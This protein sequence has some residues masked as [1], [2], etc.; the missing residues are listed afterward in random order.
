MPKKLS[1]RIKS[2][3][4]IKHE[5]NKRNGEKLNLQELET[6]ISCGRVVF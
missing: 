4:E 3:A 2:S 5:M 6:N 1:S